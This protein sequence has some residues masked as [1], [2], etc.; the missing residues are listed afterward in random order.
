MKVKISKATTIKQIFS[1]ILE[2]GKIFS[3]PIYQRDYSWRE[4]QWKEFFEDVRYSFQKNEIDSDYWGNILVFYNKEKN[5]YEI[6]DGQQRIVT[7]LLFILSLGKKYGVAEKLPL[8]F[9]ETKNDLWIKLAQ[10]QKLTQEEKRST[11]AQAKAYFEK[12]IFDNNL[13]SEQLLNHIYNTQISI[14][15]ID[16]EVE[17]NLLFGRLNTR[18]LRLDD[19]DLIKHKIFSET[20]R[21][22]GPINNDPALEKWKSIQKAVSGFNMTIESF[23]P[24]W[25][26]TRY[27]LSKESLYNSF[28]KELKPSYYLSFLD[29]L[30]HT[31]TRIESW[32]RND[33]G[34]DNRLGRNLNW[35]LKITPSSKV[36][37]V[38]IAMADVTFD[39]KI[40]LLELI[41]VFEFARAITP[42]PLIIGK[43][44]KGWSRLGINY[45]F[46]DLDDAY[47][48]FSK[49]VTSTGATGL[50]IKE[51]IKN[52]KNIMLKLLPEKE[53]FE[54]LFSSL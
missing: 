52:L 1:R 16:N 47:I 11:L 27:D 26:E 30:L 17:S 13:D 46:Y 35:L 41:T 54:E 20:E 39:G 36:V 22:S 28:E 45:E 49:K 51:E 18:G 25:W 37:S 43:E 38:I 44:V 9:T 32:R 40:N 19:V 6:V 48:K 53:D 33:T 29:S 34:N 42:P 21:N 50:E 10:H 8:K 5:E 23:I 2:D 4:E 15:I 3:I 14:V 7:I 31:A 12:N 24:L